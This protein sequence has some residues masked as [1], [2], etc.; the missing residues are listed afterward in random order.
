MNTGA[1]LVANG[2]SQ[3]IG[4]D[5]NDTFSSVASYSTLR[6]LL[7]IVASTSLE[8]LQIDVK[9]AFVKDGKKTFFLVYV[10]YIL[11]AG[12]C[13]NFLKRIADRIAAQFS[14]RVEKYVSKFLGIVFEII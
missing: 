8:Y 13:M 6:F 3:R 14:I 10:E 11:L 4:I 12:S 2:F 7:S 1:R 9:S 5:Y